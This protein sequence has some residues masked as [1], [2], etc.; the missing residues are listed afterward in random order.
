MFRLI[1]IRNCIYTI[2]QNFKLP[3]YVCKSVLLVKLFH[4]FILKILLWMIK[5]CII[6]Y[7]YI[8]NIIKC[9]NYEILNICGYLII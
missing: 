6:I 2:N 9:S 4:I 3:K 5:Y 1:N 7:L 8:L